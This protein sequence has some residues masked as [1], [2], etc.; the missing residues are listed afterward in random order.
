MRDQRG[1]SESVQW[2]VLM[3]LLLLMVLGISHAG[4]WL[5]GRTV[6]TQAALA[7][8]EAQS[9][10][11]A[12]AGVAERV[13]GTVATDGGLREV[14]VSS[15]RSGDEVVVDVRARVDSFSPWGPTGVRSRATMPLEEAR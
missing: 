13:A 3:P 10:A 6:A 1:L 5:H 12:S 11:G 4:I 14:A 2:A 8:A 15:H 7:G 9:L